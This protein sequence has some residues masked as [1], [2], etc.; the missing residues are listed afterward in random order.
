MGYDLRQGVSSFIKASCLPVLL[1]AAGSFLPLHA[2]ED[3]LA[4]YLS[5]AA[6]NN[7]SIIAARLAAEASLEQLPQAGAYDD[8]TLEAGAFLSPMELAEGRQVAQF[9]VMQ[10]FPWFG[11]RKAAR[12]EA[13]HMA[14]MNREQFRQTRD[15]VLMDVYTQWYALCALRRQVLHSEANLRWLEQLEQLALRRFASGSGSQGNAYPSPAPARSAPSSSL[16]SPSAGMDMGGSAS[17]QATSAAGAAPPM[18]DSMTSG[19]GGAAQGMSDVLRLQ[20]EKMELESRL[21]SLRAEIAA[22]TVRFNLLLNRPSGSLIAL[23]DSLAPVSFQADA[24]TIL[25]EMNEQNPM[26]A[27]L[28]EESLAYGAKA[29]MQRRMS[30]PMW[31]VG[32]QYMLMA[33]LRNATAGDNM[34]AMASET[35]AMNGKDMLMPM[36]SVSIPLYRNKYKAAQKESRL[37][38]QA[39]REKQ[40][41]AANRLE[42]E[43]HQSL[44]LLDDATRR[45]DLYRRQTALTHSVANLAAQEFTSGKAELTGVIQIQRQLLDY[46]LKEADAI[47]TYNT[48]V[49]AIR[50]LYGLFSE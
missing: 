40:T 43:L 23:P 21:E 1:L 7:P 14:N 31:G 50:R 29:V 3:S 30:Y 6:E 45:I 2:Q 41:D 37:L 5:I 25:A 9:Q 49:A 22:G 42:A 44:F 35:P 10:M 4:Y 24:Q 36:F 13:Q 48:M 33:P 47:A 19:M 26:L 20:L 12:T 34:D 28:R 17:M 32:L 39:S 18:D 15:D 11:V 16:A 8:P 46:Q 38:Q 27:M